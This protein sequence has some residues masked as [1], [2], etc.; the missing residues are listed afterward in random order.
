MEVKKE[1]RGR[2]A[3]GI[4]EVVTK[5]ELTYF[6]YSSQKVR[7]QGYK[8]TYFYDVNKNSNSPYKTEI[9]EPAIKGRKP[10]FTAEKNKAY[11][12]QPVVMVFK[13]SNRKN[14]KTKMKVWY[15]QNID[16]ILTAP[17]LPGIP[18]TAEILEV[19]V[20]E[21]FIDKNKLKYNI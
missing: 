13:S 18:E 8:I 19:N 12:N 14:A 4:N 20:G 11:N 16:Y 3:L 5:K 7:D 10:N 6:E 17:S 9:V 21:S 15:N 2:P 1:R